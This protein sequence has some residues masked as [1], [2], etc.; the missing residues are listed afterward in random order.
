MT[1]FGYG[2]YE[3]TGRRAYRGHV[4]GSKFEALL[5]PAVEQRAVERCDIRL[6]KRVIP[7]LQPGS[8]RLPAG[9]VTDESGGR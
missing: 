3:V 9:W 4:P 6:L 8:F 5:D 7:V 1:G 2:L